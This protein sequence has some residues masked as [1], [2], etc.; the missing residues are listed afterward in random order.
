M[1]YGQP[2]IKDTQT[3]VLKWPKKLGGTELQYIYILQTAIPYPKKLCILRIPTIIIG[4]YFGIL[5]IGVQFSH[6]FS[7]Q[8]FKK[9]TS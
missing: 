1:E 7:T 6:R 4:E 8:P 9:T 5:K 2:M 3:N